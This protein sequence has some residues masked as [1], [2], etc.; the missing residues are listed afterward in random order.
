MWSHTTNVISKA[1]DS[2]SIRQ[3]ELNQPP[4]ELEQLL[5]RS[6]KEA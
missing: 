3:E 5:D 4:E 1:G 2:I 6:K